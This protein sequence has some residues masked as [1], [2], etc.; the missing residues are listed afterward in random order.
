MIPS[1]EPA[2]SRIEWSKK[3]NCA[4]LLP[5]P[6]LDR[7]AVGEDVPPEREDQREGVLGHRMDGVVADVRDEDAALGAGAKVDIVGPGGG[8]CDEL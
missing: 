8:D 7:I 2:R 1:V 4:R 5:A 6:A 3:Q